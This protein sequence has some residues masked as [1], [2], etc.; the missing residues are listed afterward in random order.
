MK[1]PF[2]VTQGGRTWRTILSAVGDLLLHHVLCIFWYLR[3]VK[4]WCLELAQHR[5]LR[6][7]GSTLRRAVPLILRPFEVNAHRL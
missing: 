6:C 5:E 7:L 2:G 3:V 4:P 1:A